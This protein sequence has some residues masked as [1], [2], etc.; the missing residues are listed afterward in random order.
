MRVQ[1]RDLKV[2]RILHEDD[3]F[4]TLEIGK[5]DETVFHLQQSEETGETVGGDR[6]LTLIFV[7]QDGHA[8]AEVW[9]P[10]GV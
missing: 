7:R 9:D 5:T 8:G 10:F 2:G 1:R 4:V 6:F 3:Q